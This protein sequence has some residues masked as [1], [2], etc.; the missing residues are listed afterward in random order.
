MGQNGRMGHPRSLDTGESNDLLPVELD[1][2]PRGQLPGKDYHRF[3][4][5]V[6]QHILDRL[7]QEPLQHPDADAGEVR[8]SLTEHLALGLRPE[9][10]EFQHLE[11]KG[12]LR[13]QLVVA[14]QSL[15]RSQEIRILEHQ[16]LGIENL[17]FGGARVLGCALPQLVEMPLHIGDSLPEPLDLARNITL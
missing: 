5:A 14:N 2:Q 15:D 13:A 7:P 16:D 1:R 10:A 11:L 3:A 9:Y 4:T 12:A 17:G 8:T 6:F